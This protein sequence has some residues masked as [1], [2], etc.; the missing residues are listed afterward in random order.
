[1]NKEE[2]VRAVVNN[3]VDEMHS[4]EIHELIETFEDN[5]GNGLFCDRYD[6]GSWFYDLMNLADLEVE[7]VLYDIANE[8]LEYELE[9]AKEELL[10]RHISRG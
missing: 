5:D 8:H 4:G 9:E 10:S 7:D 2:I 1:M 6:L 3:I